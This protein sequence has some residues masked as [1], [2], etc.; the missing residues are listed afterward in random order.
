[1]EKAYVNDLVSML[2]KK[3]IITEG[4]IKNIKSNL[5][6]IF[7]NEDVQKFKTLLTDVNKTK[8]RKNSQHGY[9]KRGNDRVKDLL[10]IMGKAGYGIT[11]K[12]K[13]NILDIGAGSC[14]ISLAIKDHFTNSNVMVLDE[15]LPDRQK[16]KNLKVVEYNMNGDI[17]LNPES[18]DVVIM[19]VV[20]HHIHPDIRRS[21]A[22]NISRLLKKNGLLI[23][24][25]HYLVDVEY[26][27]FYIECVHQFWYMF[28]DEKEDPLYLTSVYDFDK[29]FVDFNLYYVGVPELKRIGTQHIYYRSYT[30][31]SYD[32]K[33]GFSPDVIRYN[34]ELIKNLKSICGEYP[35]VKN[36]IPSFLKNTT[37]IPEN[38]IV[39]KNAK[40]DEEAIKIYIKNILNQHTMCICPNHDINIDYTIDWKIL[41]KN[42]YDIRSWIERPYKFDYFSSA[43]PELFFMLSDGSYDPEIT[44][45]GGGTAKYKNQYIEIICKTDTQKKISELTD[46]YT[47]KERIKLSKH[48]FDWCYAD[49]IHTMIDS[50]IDSK[51]NMTPLNIINYLGTIQPNTDFGP[52]IINA[53]LKFV[54]EWDLKKKILDMD[55]G[56]GDVMLSAI[57]LNMAYTGLIQEKLL[58]KK[59]EKIIDDFGSPIKHKVYE[60]L[61]ELLEA[62]EECDI[63]TLFGSNS[64]ENKDLNLEL[65]KLTWNI[66]TDKGYLMIRIEDRITQS[67][68]IIKTYVINN[69]EKSKYLGAILLS[70]NSNYKPIPVHIWQ[71]TTIS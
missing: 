19:M 25:E 1:M 53:L 32:Y 41:E 57:S 26:F 39:L 20:L 62:E 56:Y 18:V 54:M 33:K 28:N 64:K 58:L 47:E 22:R 36:Y 10:D 52:L 15:K 51:T 70:R 67:V 3:Y 11:G 2:D 17:N 31:R 66:L 29:L 50:F 65:L 12:E 35:T 23:I 48:A 61:Y 63:I 69:L 71:K 21:I 43:I 40:T 14:E 49:F 60:S 5:S 44:A 6:D 55:A 68:D 27:E 4:D 34:V 8:E 9:N 13:Y 16:I 37:N 38:D 42:Q 30:K 46:F 7:R 24:R 59:Y 45:S